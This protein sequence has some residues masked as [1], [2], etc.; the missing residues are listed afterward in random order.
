MTRQVT[1]AALTAGLSALLGAAVLSAQDRTEIATVPFAFH[2]QQTS[3]EAGKYR[4]DESTTSGVFRISEESG[5]AIYL[6]EHPVGEAKSIQAK[7]VFACYG[8]KCEL[9]KIEMPGSN[10]EWGESKSSLEKSLSHK[11]GA[12]LMISVPLKAR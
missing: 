6:M 7:L 4:V 10:V 5:R 2:A 1:K 9:A 8:G 11:L 12:S 3:F